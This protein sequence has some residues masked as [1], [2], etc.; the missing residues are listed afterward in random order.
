[1]PTLTRSGS[2]DLPDR[3][4]G[5]QRLEL[6]PSL[7]RRSPDFTHRGLS[8]LLRDWLRRQLLP[9]SLLPARWQIPYR[10]QQL[11]LAL[12]GG[13]LT[14]NG[15]LLL[16]AAAIAADAWQLQRERETVLARTLTS[17]TALNN[18]LTQISALGIPA[19]TLVMAI[20]AHRALFEELV[21]LRSA[22]NTVS[23]ALLAAPEYR[24]ETLSWQRDSWQDT[25]SR[26]AP[27]AAPQGTSTRACPPAESTTPTHPGVWI[28][29]EAQIDP[30]LP[31][32]QIVVAHERF[33][34]ALSDTP[35]LHLAWEEPPVRVSP[36]ATL[37][38][39]AQRVEIGTLRLCLRL[40]AGGS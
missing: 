28:E 25:S 20:D 14:L 15:A 23:S 5:W 4:L 19:E 34:A 9:P 7:A 40:E 30:N 32:R 12:I 26:A 21:P 17:E 2:P 3:G 36:D 1:M 6:P 27:P 10:R 24:L 22:L 38:G 37:K 16:T 29:I 18:T 31:L 13:S 33:R 35:G 39:D 8:A 11:R